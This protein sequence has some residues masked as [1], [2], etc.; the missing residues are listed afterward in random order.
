MP[1]IASFEEESKSA[2]EVIAPQSSVLGDMSGFLVT[3]GLAKDRRGAEITLLVLVGLVLCVTIF[4]FIRAFSGGSST[5]PE[6]NLRGYI[7]QMNSRQ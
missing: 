3:K 6:D 2:Q 1:P 4:F 5:I 7:Q